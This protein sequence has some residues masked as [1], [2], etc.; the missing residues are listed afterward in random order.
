MLTCKSPRKV[1]RYAYELARRCLPRY[2][3]KCSRHDYTRAQ[4]FACLV[5]REHQKQTYRG[6]EALLRDSD[7]WCKQIGMRKVPDHNTLCR[8]FHALLSEAKVSR[9]MDRLL[10][11]MFVGRAMRFTCAIDSTVYDSRYRSRHYEQNCRHYSVGR[12]IAANF[13][14][15]RS[16]KRTPKLSLSVETRCHVILA[17]H[18]RT[19]MG[20]DAPDFARLLRET[21]RRLPRI[22]AVL[23]DAGYDS[24]K[25][26]EV[27]R[28]ELGIRSW[29]KAGVGR[30]T[31][32]P[33]ASRYRRMMKKKLKGSQ[34]G[35]PYGQRS[36]AETVNS[37]MKRNLGDHLRAR[38]PEGRRKEQMLRVLTHNLSILSARHEEG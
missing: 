6:V 22:R 27:A 5:V 17:A 23:A 7:H 9:L 2:S 1:M 28:E 11:W 4:L 21:R 15:S 29:I 25:N 36:Q 8:A 38:T 19:G 37:M 13:R 14:R 31:N 3:C 20:S 18:P 30:Q 32:K 35:K 24:H 12:G 10:R 16:A 33:L 34:K 26:H